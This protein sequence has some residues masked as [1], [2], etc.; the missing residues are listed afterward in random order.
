M[1][2]H[3]LHEALT[4]LRVGADYY[5]PLERL[6]ALAGARAADCLQEFA[7]ALLEGRALAL[8]EAEAVGLAAAR[9]WLRRQRLDD[10]RLAPLVLE[11]ADGRPRERAL[12]PLPPPLP[13]SRAQIAWGRRSDAKSAPP[14]PAP[15]ADLAAAVRR[16]P[17]PERRALAAIYGV[18]GAPR[19]GRRSRELLALAERAVAR[20]RQALPQEHF[21]VNL[22][23]GR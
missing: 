17:T 19:R 3:G 9:R 5:E 15:D 11:D 22:F 10:G 14:P 20:L 6:V 2:I 4:E 13:A 23:A 18:G 8:P 1:T 16:L 21:G 7:A 12:R